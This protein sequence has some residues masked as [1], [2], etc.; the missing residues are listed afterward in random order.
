MKCCIEGCGREARYKEAQLCQKHY[1]RT[2]PK[3]AYV[4]VPRDTPEEMWAEACRIAR[5]A[6]AQRQRC[7]DAMRKAGE[8]LSA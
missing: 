2:R 4:P 3:V 5:E 7:F 1:H 6:R 8:G